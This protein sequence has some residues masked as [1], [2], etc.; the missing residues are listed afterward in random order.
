[1]NHPRPFS[2]E[3][4]EK[5]SLFQGKAQKI[6]LGQISFDSKLILAPMAG[7]IV[8]GLVYDLF[9]RPLFGKVDL[10]VDQGLDLPRG[11]SNVVNG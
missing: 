3:L 8:G 10:K 1:M 11:G 6:K 7:A 9:V 5:I 4:T 2:S